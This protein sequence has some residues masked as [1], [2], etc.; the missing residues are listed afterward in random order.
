MLPPGARRIVAALADP[1]DLAGTWGVSADGRSPTLWAACGP[2]AG[3]WARRDPRRLALILPPGR[4]PAAYDWSVVAGHGPVL[5]VRCGP[6]PDSTVAALIEA[7]LVD[8][9]GRIL[10]VASGRRFLPAEAV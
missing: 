6:V 4:D 8:G 9:A 1:R 7:L 3:K 10:D 2:G 5:L